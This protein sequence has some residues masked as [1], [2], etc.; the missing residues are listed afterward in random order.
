MA[1]EILGAPDA[2]RMDPML[3]WMDPVLRDITKILWTLSTTA[4]HILIAQRCTENL[5]KIA[6]DVRK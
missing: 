3:F 6:P 2:L 1:R 5:A 4:Q